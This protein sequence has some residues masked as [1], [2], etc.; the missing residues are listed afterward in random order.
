MAVGARETGEEPAKN[1]V[2]NFAR[3]NELGEGAARDGEGRA[4][5]V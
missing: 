3:W 2:G 5:E 1:K 4:E